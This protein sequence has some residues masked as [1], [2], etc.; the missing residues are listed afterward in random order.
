VNVSLNGQLALKYENNT[1]SKGQ[2]TTMN[3]SGENS[4]KANEKSHDSALG[5]NRWTKLPPEQENELST[6]SRDERSIRSDNGNSVGMDQT[7]L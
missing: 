5:A 3:N 2:Q 7:K 6:S 1:T 4:Y